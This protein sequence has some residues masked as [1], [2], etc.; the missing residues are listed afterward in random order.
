MCYFQFNDFANIS[1]QKNFEAK[2]LLINLS[3]PNI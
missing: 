2:K 3:R 1:K